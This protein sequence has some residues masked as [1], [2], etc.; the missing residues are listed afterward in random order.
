VIEGWK[1]VCDGIPGELGD[2]ALRIRKKPDTGEGRVF[3]HIEPVFY[4]VRY[5]DQIPSLA[6]NG[7]DLIVGMKEEEAFALDKE[8]DLKLRVNMLIKEFL[9]KR[10]SV[11]VIGF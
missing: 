3:P 7:I 5:T 4:T 8:S 10:G 6:Q 9:S 11:R 1:A 2:P